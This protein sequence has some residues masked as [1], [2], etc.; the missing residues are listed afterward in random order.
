[1]P[2]H[3]IRRLQ[4]TPTFPRRRTYK[5]N[6]SL[7][8]RYPTPTLSS[9]LRDS[10]TGRVVRIKPNHGWFHRIPEAR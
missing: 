9:C 6:A 5:G 3:P 1:M 8:K 10:R 7:S 2:T 4:P